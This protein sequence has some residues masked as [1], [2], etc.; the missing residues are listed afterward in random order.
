[1]LPRQALPASI[2]KPLLHSASQI[3]SGHL[4]FGS[5]PC[6][7]RWMSQ[8]IVIFRE[9]LASKMCRNV[10]EALKDPTI[11]ADEED[12]DITKFVSRSL[13]SPKSM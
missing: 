7:I 9:N 13:L 11:A 4:H 6:R 1:M 12:I 5:N 2:V 8:E 3:P 10:I